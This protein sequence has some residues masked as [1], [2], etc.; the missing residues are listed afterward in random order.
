MNGQ[1]RLQATIARLRRPSPSPSLPPPPRGRDREEEGG[2]LNLE[3]TTP[4]EALLLA[5]LAELEKDVR[6][7]QEQNKWLSRLVGG[8]VLTALLNLVIK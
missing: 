3:P 7:I 5:R 1:E 6:E 4:F 2:R 8:A